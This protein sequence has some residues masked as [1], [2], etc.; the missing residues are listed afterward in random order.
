MVVGWC[1]FPWGLIMTPV[2]V[3]RNIGGLMRSTESAT[4]SEKLEQLVRLNIAAYAMQR[5]KQQPNE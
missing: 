2:Q 5:A 1:G 4:P 3:A